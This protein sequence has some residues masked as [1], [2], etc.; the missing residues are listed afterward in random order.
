MLR[1]LEATV[2]AEVVSSVNTLIVLKRLWDAP[3]ITRAQVESLTQVSA[4]EATEL[5]ETLQEHGIVKRLGGSHEWVAGAAVATPAESTADDDLP[6]VPAIEWLR[7]KLAQGEPVY[8]ADA[9]EALGLERSTVTQLLRQLRQDG[10]ARIDP[11][12]PQR[13]P[14]TKWI[15]VVGR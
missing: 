14:R 15:G 6:S 12:G 5:M 11:S 3:R 9:A 8:A 13:G 10:V 1:K 7:A 2:P 4:P